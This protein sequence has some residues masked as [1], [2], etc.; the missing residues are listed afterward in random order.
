MSH[1][2][3]SL[4]GA[5]AGKTKVCFGVQFVNGKAVIPLKDTENVRR[6]LEEDWGAMATE[7]AI[8]EGKLPQPYVAPKTVPAEKVVTA[9]ISNVEPIDVEDD[10]D[11]EDEDDN[12]DDEDDLLG[13]DEDGND[14]EAKAGTKKIVK[15]AV[16]PPAKPVKPPKHR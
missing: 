4:V 10:S 12:D 1:I 14:N 3:Y 8:A 16:K 13:E 2:E 6:I 7:R 15:K 5:N 9:T 11:G